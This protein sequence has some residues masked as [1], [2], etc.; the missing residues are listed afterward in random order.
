VYRSDNNTISEIEIYIGRDNR[1]RRVAT[2]KPL[3]PIQ[4]ILDDGEHVEAS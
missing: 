3:F 2:G 1:V 4:A